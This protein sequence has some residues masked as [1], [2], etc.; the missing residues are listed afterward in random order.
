M[1]PIKVGHNHFTENSNQL[2]NINILSSK[3]IIKFNCP[4]WKSYI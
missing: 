3:K 4:F 1:S 2:Q